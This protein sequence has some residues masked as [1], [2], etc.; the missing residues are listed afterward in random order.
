MTSAALAEAIR[1]FGDPRGYLAAASTGLPPR[2]AIEALTADL[3]AWAVGDID[4]QAYDAV[5]ERA[6]ASY[7][8]IVGMPVARVAQG[9]QASVLTSLVAAAVPDGA[10]VLMPDGDFSSI[11]FPFLQL[12]GIRVRTVPLTAMA[13]AITSETWLVVFSQVQSATG[14]L[15]DVPAILEAASRHG[16]YTFCDLTQA[17]GVLPVDA[18]LFDVTVCHTYKWLCAPRGVAFLTVSERFDPLLTPIQ[19]GW[20]AGA[21]VW[22]S[23]YGPAMHLATDARRFDVSPAWQAWIGAEQSLALFAALDLHEVWELTA[24]LG[25]SLCDALDIPLQ[26]QAIVT[27]PDSSGHDL[28]KLIAAGIRASGRAGRLRASFHLWNTEADVNAVVKALRT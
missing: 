23:T 22:T 8:A 9:S 21:D 19:A 16:A 4:P 1:Q 24:G 25:E 26:R 28:H 15:A 7:A 13:D 10:E 18:S 11:E 27:W 3:A 20:Y 17:A 2:R 14:V 6:R 5:I 12:P